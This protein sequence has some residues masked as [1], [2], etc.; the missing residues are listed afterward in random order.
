[1]RS[2]LS[3]LGGDGGDRRHTYRGVGT[4]GFAPERIV[5]TQVDPPD[6]DAFCDAERERLA[7]LPLDARWTP[8]PRL[9]HVG[10]D[11]SQVNSR[12]SA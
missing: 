2:W 10:V 12:T 4:A 9:R 7:A 5:P 6:F 3:A 8:L 11:C 1:M